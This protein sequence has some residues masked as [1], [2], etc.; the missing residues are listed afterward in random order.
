MMKEATCV[1]FLPAI[2]SALSLSL[3]LILVMNLSL[4][5]A[6]EPAE[7][8]PQPPDVFDLVILGEGKTA[9]WMNVEA[10]LKPN[11][12]SAAQLE[13]EAASGA[14]LMSGGRMKALTLK[15]GAAEQRER[16]EVNIADGKLRTV[17]VR[18]R[19]LNAD[20]KAWM[21]IDREVRVK[22]PGAAPSAPALSDDERVPVVRTLPDGTKVVERMTRREARERGLP[23]NG[24]PATTFRRIPMNGQPAAKKP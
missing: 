3:S 23:E 20:G 7:N 4:G 5:F 10:V 1:P 2:R 6:D 24:V 12:D 9:D 15:R 8:E 22:K 21:I 18:L 17:K 13:V 14:R 16:M 11:L 19:L